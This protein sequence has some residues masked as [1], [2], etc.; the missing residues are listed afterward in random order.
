MNWCRSFLNPNIFDEALA[1]AIQ[2]RQTIISGV[3]P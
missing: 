2:E 3:A 1:Q